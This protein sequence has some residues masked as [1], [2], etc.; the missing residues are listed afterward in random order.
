MS[1]KEIK[2]E[3]KNDKPTSLLPLIS[4]VMEKYIDDQT[5]DSLQINEFL[6]IYQ[7]IYQLLSLVTGYSDKNGNHIGMILVDIRNV[8]NTLDHNILSKVHRKVQCIGFSEET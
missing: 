3:A 8:F 4:K 5:K 7:L 2:T 6:Y 1:K